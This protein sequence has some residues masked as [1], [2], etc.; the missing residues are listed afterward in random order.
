LRRC[1]PYVIP[2]IVF[3]DVW[4]VVAPALDKKEKWKLPEVKP[5][6]QI[7]RMIENQSNRDG[8]A[9]LSRFSIC[10]SRTPKNRLAAFWKD[11]DGIAAAIGNTIS[12]KTGRPVGIIFL[13][14]KKDVP[15]KNWI[16]PGFLK[17]TPSLMEDYKTVGSQYPD[18]PYYLTNAR[19]YLAEWGHY[20]RTHIPAMMQTKAVPDGSTWGT[21]PSP[22]PNIGD[23]TA[24]FEYNVYMYCFTPATLNGI[25]FI[26]GKAMVADGGANFAP[27]MTVLANSFKTRFGLEPG[28]D[29]SWKSGN[30]DI[31]FI[32]TLP[33]KTLAPEITV[34][35]IKGTSTA[36]EISD[37][38]D[39]TK[40]IEA[41]AK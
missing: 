41:L 7:V 33:D 29:G 9:E 28:Q 40:V 21:F 39:A 18:N 37:W 35:K 34:P 27:E 15:I 31:P 12:A 19:R 16:A 8:R 11:A 14:A 24:C 10:T 20:W 2:G 1:I 6:G 23:S 4:C 5:S 36:V 3:G 30:N 26:T 17:D 13:E 38:A 22:K 25:V 32:Y